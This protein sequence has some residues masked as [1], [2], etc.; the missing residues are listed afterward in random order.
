MK[1]LKIVNDTRFDLVDRLKITTQTSFQSKLNGE[2][3]EHTLAQLCAC[4]ARQQTKRSFKGQNVK[5]RLTPTK[6]NGK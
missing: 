2:I 6:N 5:W 4:L 1:R 3:L